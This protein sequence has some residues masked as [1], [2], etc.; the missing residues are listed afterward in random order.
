MYI[1]NS[2]IMLQMNLYMD[3]YYTLSKIKLD[4]KL[5]RDFRIPPAYR[6]IS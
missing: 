4:K 3:S 6:I 1:L 5:E 2:E